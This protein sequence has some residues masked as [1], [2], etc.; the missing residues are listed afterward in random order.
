MHFKNDYRHLSSHDGLHTKVCAVSD[1]V[2]RKN[3]AR[4][5]ACKLLVSQKLVTRRYQNQNDLSFEK[6]IDHG[7][8]L[9]ASKVSKKKRAE[10][11]TGQQA[12]D[13]LLEH[14]DSQGMRIRSRSSLGEES[15][16]RFHVIQILQE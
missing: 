6:W 5:R 10:L 2:A 13:R 3:N 12:A 4:E 15:S 11:P 16:E 7:I 9:T 1:K 8:L 14:Q